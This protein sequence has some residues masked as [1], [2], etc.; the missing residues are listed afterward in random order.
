MQE[1]CRK[2]YIRQKSNLTHGYPIYTFTDFATVATMKISHKPH[3]PV[4]ETG[5]VFMAGNRQS[6][7]PKGF[8]TQEEKMNMPKVTKELLLRGEGLKCLRG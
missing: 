1:K 3:T 5:G 4:H 8:L 6:L 7:G 2:L